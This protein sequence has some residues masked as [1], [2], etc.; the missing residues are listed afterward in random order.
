MKK[1]TKPNLSA[2]KQALL[3]LKLLDELVQATKDDFSRFLAA[4]LNFN[5]VAVK[6]INVVAGV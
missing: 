1:P 2:I 5:K 6:L 3:T 4:T